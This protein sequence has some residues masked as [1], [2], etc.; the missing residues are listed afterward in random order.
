[1]ECFI[2]ALEVNHSYLCKTHAELLYNM[3][4]E[5]IGVIESPDWKYHCAICGEHENRRIIELRDGGYFCSECIKKAH[6]EYL[7]TP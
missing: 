7:I 5:N 2:C 1:M 4:L 6:K 3:I